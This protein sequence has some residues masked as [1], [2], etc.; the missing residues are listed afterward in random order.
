MSHR[1]A[2]AFDSLEKLPL[3]LQVFGNRFDNP[4]G[5]AAPREVVFEISGGDE[6]RRFWRKESRGAGFFRRFKP[7]EHDPV[8]DSGTR[9]RES[10]ALFLRTVQWPN[11]R[12]GRGS[13]P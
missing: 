12:P 11:L 8:S 2:H 1:L 7:R 4:I 5:F 13:L 3:D 10:F 9:K 6:S